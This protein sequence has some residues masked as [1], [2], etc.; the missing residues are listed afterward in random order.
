MKP[1]FF[2]EAVSYTVC[3]KTYF[4]CFN[5]DA[6]K[7]LFGAI[8]LLSGGEGKHIV[9]NGLIFLTKKEVKTEASRKEH[10]E[11]IYHLKK[12]KYLIL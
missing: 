4:E 2:F 6:L 12:N 5:I 8:L 9:K 1:H 11:D 3:F 7:K 10:T